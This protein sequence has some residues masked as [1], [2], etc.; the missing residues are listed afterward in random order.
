[1]ALTLLL[2]NNLPVDKA[3]QD[4]GCL[5]ISQKKCKLADSLVID[6]Q[7]KPEYHEL[8]R[9]ER[10]ANVRVLEIIIDEVSIRNSAICQCSRDGGTDAGKSR[11]RPGPI[12]P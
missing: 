9:E 1:M 2:V 8:L 4:E 11:A 6:A 10:A 12:N 3:R 5:R 7:K